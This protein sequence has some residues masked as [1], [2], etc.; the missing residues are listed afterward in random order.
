MKKLVV[1]NNNLHNTSHVLEF[2]IDQAKRYDY[3]IEGLFLDLEDTS[4]SYP[5]PNDLPLTE[6]DVT[7]GSPEEE[8]EKIIQ[9]YID[10][11]HNECQQAGVRCRATRLNEETF[12][13]VAAT[14]DAF[15]M[16]AR[17]QQHTDRPDALFSRLSCPVVAVSESS[18]KIDNVLFGFDG[19]EDSEYAVRKYIDLFP[20]AGSKKFHL[21]TVNKE[22]ELLEDRVFIND[23]LEKKF[24]GISLH[25]LEGDQSSVFIEFVRQFPE[26]SLV[27]MGAYGR[28]ALSR[29]FRPSL[30]EKVFQE[31]RASVF[32]AHE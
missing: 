22:L 23:F 28:S 1:L 11:F 9:E 6:V 29:F 8:N 30:A 18:V 2:A 4:S 7:S 13:E 32:L 24:P 3:E 10:Y 14:A 15:L 27:V 21:V 12:L 26:N 19:S 17:H 25:H 31:T 5:F 16:D 20:E